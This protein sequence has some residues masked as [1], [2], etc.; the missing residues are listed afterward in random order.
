MI[1]YPYVYFQ[2]VLKQDP[3]PATRG[4][5]QDDLQEYGMELYDVNIRW[6]VSEHGVF[7]TT[8]HQQEVYGILAFFSFC[9]GLYLTSSWSDL[10]E[11]C[12]A[13]THKHIKSCIIFLWPGMH[14]NM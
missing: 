1:S 2:K 6:K 14:T 8:I 4:G 13:T 3:R 10:H 12:E 11:Q 5:V 9:V 7:V